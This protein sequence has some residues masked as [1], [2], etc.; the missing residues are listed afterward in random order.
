[1][2]KGEE[3]TQ[4]EVSF[5]GWSDDDT[6]WPG[7]VAKLTKIVEEQSKRSKWRLGLGVCIGRP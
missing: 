7:Q 6:S 3:F 1:M 5:G 2:R 4:G